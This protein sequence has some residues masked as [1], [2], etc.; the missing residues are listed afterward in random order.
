M[1]NYNFNVN[2]GGM[3]DVLSN[4]LY[5]TPKVFIRELL[6]NA[7]DAIV[8]RKNNDKNSFEPSIEISVNEKNSIIFTDNGSG[9]TEEEIHKFIS[10]IGQSS[11]RDDTNSF[12]GRFGIGLLSCFMVTSEIV[13]RTRSYK[14]PDKIYEWHGFDDGHYSVRQIDYKMKIGTEITINAMTD[15]AKTM[16]TSGNIMSIVRYYGLPLPYPVF[17]VSG[18]IKLKANIHF[19]STSKNAHDN[20]LTMGKKIFG[21]DYDFIDYI[22][23]ESKSGI[24]SGVAFILPYTVSAA[25]KNRHRIYLKNILLTENGS[26]I[27]PEWAFFVQCFFNTNSLSPTAS[28]EDF[29]QNEMLKTA[30]DEISHCISAYFEK[31]SIQNPSLLAKIVSIHGMALKS[32]SSENEHLF[33]IFMPYFKFETSFGIIDGKSLMMYNSNI[34]YTEDPDI[35]KLLKPVF[36]EKDELLINVAYAHDTSLIEMIDKLNLSHTEIV[37]ENLLNTILEDSDNPE[38]FE[39]LCSVAEFVLSEY[40]CDIRIKKISPA[41]LNALYTVNS[42]GQIRK[43]IEETKKKS[44]EIFNDMLSA[45]EAEFKEKS[46][47]ILYL[48]CENP[49]IQ[50][51]A[52]VNDLEKLK[53]CCKIIY[54][55]ALVSGGFSVTGDDLAN[56]NESLIKLIEWGIQ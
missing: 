23:L 24:F 12:I 34:F 35:F 10:V 38:D 31:L 6:Q 26:S 32:V 7:V 27:L 29:Y 17:I 3:I 15:E 41:Q 51:L 21:N 56:L 46:S 13:L 4:H 9:L 20:V 37:N 49:L 14:T 18:G 16:F 54:I 39:T 36:Y 40:D 50:K 2:L 5:S 25:S 53:V 8:L 22:P 33:K 43:D 11:K 45:F 55:Q 47:A 19:D 52:S 30:S 42:E 48:N 1:E 28:R 44:D